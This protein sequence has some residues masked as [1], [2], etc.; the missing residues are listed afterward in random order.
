M[1]TGWLDDFLRL[2][3]EGN[4][5]RAAEA[6]NL[7]QPAFSRRIRAL[8]EWAGAILID[9]ETHRIALTPAGEALSAVASEVLRQLALGRDHVREIGA[10]QANILRF[11]STH[12]LSITFFPVWLRS[13]EQDQEYGA[14]SLIADN[15]V[16]CERIMLDGAADFLLCHHHPAASTKLD[17]K[18]FLSIQLGKDT[19]VPVSAPDHRGSAIY[20]LPGTDQNPI[21]FLEFDERSGMGR[22]LTASNVLSQGA[23]ALKQVFRS[24][25]ASLI[26]TMARDRR[27]VA[28]APLSLAEAHFESGSL[29]R[30]GNG[31]WD[32]PIEIRLV[33]PRA[34]LNPAVEAFWKL[35][36]ARF[37]A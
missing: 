36:S 15:M 1:E 8:E 12:A 31:E 29:V 28:W 30:A 17:P 2:V 3:E 7:S 9:R 10:S 20:V 23:L 11:A 4:F 18:S 6:R 34:R 22:I 33:R 35:I 37:Q 24:H 32:V 26:L 21:P 19:L 27:G 25:L 5:S 13:M 14:V 16:G